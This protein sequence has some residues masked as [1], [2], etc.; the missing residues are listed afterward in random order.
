MNRIPSLSTDP[1]FRDWIWY[2]HMKNMSTFIRLKRH[3]SCLRSDLSID[4]LRARTLELINSFWDTCIK[5]QTT[6]NQ[7]KDQIILNA[8]CKIYRNRNQ[9]L[10]FIVISLI[11]SITNS[12]FAFFMFT[13]ITITTTIITERRYLFEKIDWKDIRHE[14]WSFQPKK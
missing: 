10:I 6:K 13:M 5:E 8:F 14:N 7:L 2:F 3:N 9:M 12:V 4:L 1:D 11:N